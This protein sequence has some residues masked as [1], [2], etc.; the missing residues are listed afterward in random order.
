[1]SD[2]FVTTTNLDLTEGRGSVRPLVIHSTV[3]NA[4]VH[5]KTAGVM[6][7]PSGVMTHR[8][9]PERDLPRS[10]ILHG[11]LRD[12]PVVVGYFRNGLGTQSWG[13]VPERI[14]KLSD[15]EKARLKALD[16]ILGDRVSQPEP[17]TVTKEQRAIA[18]VWSGFY[19]SIADHRTKT[20]VPQIVG[21]A[22]LVQEFEDVIA[23][24][25]EVNAVIAHARLVNPSLRQA[26]VT[27][28][29]FGED[30]TLSERTADWSEPEGFDAVAKPDQS[31]LL[32]EYEALSRKAGLL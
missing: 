14:E 24:M 1:M 27:I 17:V 3:E 32:A 5:G 30:F 16:A 22:S 11:T 28:V 6:G 29:E 23:D 31:A 19:G 12:L 21:F 15:D 4:Y 13:I 18:V 25:D 2:I 8:V 9:D 7:T 20:P 10:A 26:H